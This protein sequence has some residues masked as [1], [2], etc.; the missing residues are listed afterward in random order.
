MKNVLLQFSSSYKLLKVP[1]YIS[2][3]DCERY[4]FLCNLEEVYGSVVLDDDELS[5]WSDVPM[6]IID[7]EKKIQVFSEIIKLSDKE[8]EERRKFFNMMYGFNGEE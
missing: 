1:K 2:I 3:E 4:V 7:T 6:T 8:M 5:N